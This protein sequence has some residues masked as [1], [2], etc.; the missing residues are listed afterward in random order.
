M[1]DDLISRKALLEILDA[2]SD[3]AIA[4]PAQMIYA[5]AAKIV[6]ML[7]VVDAE[8][9]RHSKWVCRIPG[10]FSCGV[11]KRL[12]IG[13]RPTYYCPECGSKMDGE[14]DNDRS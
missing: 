9:V 14:D 1:N 3:M 7:P 11:C 13:N 12:A 6:E 2:K 5:N 10:V 8:P 4:T